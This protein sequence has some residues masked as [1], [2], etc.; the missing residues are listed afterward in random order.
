MPAKIQLTGRE[1]MNMFQPTI[2]DVIQIE[3]EKTIMECATV[4]MENHLSRGVDVATEIL[5][6]LHKA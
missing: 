4:A 3:R 6:L 1:I 2:R 5:K